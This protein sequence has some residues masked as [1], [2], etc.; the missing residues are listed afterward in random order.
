MGEKPSPLGEDFSGPAGPETR[1]PRYR[2]KAGHYCCNAVRDKGFF[3]A[4]AKVGFI[5]LS[6]KAAE[7]TA[8]R[9]LE[10]SLS[11]DSPQ[12]TLINDLRSISHTGFSQ[13]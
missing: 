13:G 11:N 10:P 7:A 8:F 3:W 1:L 9:R 12:A 4:A 5:R 6:E 2:S